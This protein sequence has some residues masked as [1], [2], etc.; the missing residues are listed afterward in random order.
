MARRGA[1]GDEQAKA[2]TVTTITKIGKG[3]TNGDDSHE[4]WR[5]AQVTTVTRIGTQPLAADPTLWALTPI[6]AT[7]S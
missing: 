1:K 4:D 2:P 7:S 6:P 3:G 5:G